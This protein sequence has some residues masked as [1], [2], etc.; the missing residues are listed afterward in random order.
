MANYYKV[1]SQGRNFTPKGTQKLA[2]GMI[3]IS[4]I[5]DFGSYKPF[6]SVGGGAARNKSNTVNLTSLIILER[7][8]VEVAY[9]AIAGVI[10][11]ISEERG[12]GL[13]GRY[14]STSNQNISDT[15]MFINA[16]YNL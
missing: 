1:A 14:L 8:T 6:S 13:N 4:Y 12:V 9:Q 15:A 2:T 3:N 5:L 16:R 11:K 10:Y 7:D